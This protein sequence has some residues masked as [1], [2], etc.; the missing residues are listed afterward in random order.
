[1][2]EKQFR[3]RSAILECLM[4]SDCH[5]SAE[6]IYEMLQKDNPDISM[7]TVYRNLSRFKE[8]G[9]IV[10]LG[11]VN[12]KERFDSETKPHVHFVCN[13]CSAVLD[14]PGMGDPQFLCRDAANRSGCQ[15]DSCTLT[16]SGLCRDCRG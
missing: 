13:G 10:S 12:G 3:K 7:A 6:M 5:P 2:K 11:T 4:A 16:F 8:Q 15:V 14:M 1:M 9:L